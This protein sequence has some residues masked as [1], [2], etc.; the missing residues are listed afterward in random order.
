MTLANQRYILLLLSMR[1][2]LH[3][4]IYAQVT[5]IKDLHAFF[6]FKM[7][8]RRKRQLRVLFKHFYHCPVFDKEQKTR[9]LWTNTSLKLNTVCDFDLQK[10]FIFFVNSNAPRHSRVGIILRFM[11]TRHIIH[12][13]YI[14]PIRAN[15]YHPLNRTTINKKVSS[16]EARV[17]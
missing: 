9:S 14:F 5:F 13:N 16:L 4:Y 2:P 15:P 11:W 7:R 10:Y 12:V 1:F 6:V 17:L 8:A 3:V